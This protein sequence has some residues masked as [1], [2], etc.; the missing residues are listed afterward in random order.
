MPSGKFVKTRNILQHTR[1][2]Q[3]KFN[4]PNANGIESNTFYFNPIK[5]WNSLPNNLKNCGNIHTYKKGVKRYLL[6][7]ATEEAG[8]K[9]VFL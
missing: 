2:S 1:S 3:W 8:K 5:D 6:E 7:T 4:A 9:Y